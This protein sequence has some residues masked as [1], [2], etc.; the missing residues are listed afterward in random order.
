MSNEDWAKKLVKKCVIP[1]TAMDD[2]RDPQVVVRVNTEWWVTTDGETFST[3]DNAIK[4]QM[5]LL[6]EGNLGD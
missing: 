1:Q 4:W 6:K 3:E 5:N 2:I